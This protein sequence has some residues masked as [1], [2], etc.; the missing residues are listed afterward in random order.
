MK[1][2][3][4]FLGEM[5]NPEVEAFLQA[6]HTVIVPTGA[7]EQHGPH[8]PLAHRRA[9]PEGDRPPR[10]ARRRRRRRAADQLRAVVP[11]RRLHAA[12][13][14]SAS[15]PSWRSSRISATSFAA[16]GFKRIVFLNG[17]Y[18]NTY[19]IAYA[20]ANAAEKLPRGREGIP[21]Q[22]LGRDA[23]RGARAST[24]SLEKGMHAN[25]AETSAVLAINPAPGRHGQGQRRVPAVPGVHGEQRRGAHGVLLQRPRVGVLAPRS[26]ARGATRAWPPAEMGERYLEAGVRVDD[27]RA[28]E[29]R[30]HLRRDAA[31]MSPVMGASRRS[32]AAL[33]PCAAAA[34]RR[35]LAV[36]RA[37]R[38]GACDGASGRRRRDRAR[39]LCR[40]ARI[41]TS[42]GS[43][44][45]ELP[46]EGATA[47]LLE[48]TSQQWLTEQEVE[49]PLWTHWLTVVRPARRSTSDIGL[50]F[51]TGGG[52]DGRPPDAPP[53]W[54]VD[55][56]RDTGTVVA[57]LRHGAEP[58]GRL[59]GRSGARSRAR[60]TTSSPTRGIKFLRTGDE[61]WP[62]RLPMTKSAV[63]AMDAVTAFTAIARRRR[64]RPSTR[65]V[66]SGAS[67]RGWTT[68]TTAA[69]DR[70]VVAIAPPS[71]TCSTSSRRSST[72]GAP[73]APGADAV[74][75]YVE[76]GI[77]DWMGTPRVPRADADR[78]AVRVPRPA[79][80]AEVPGE[81]AGRSVLPA[82]LVAVL[83]RRPARREVRSATCRTSATG[84]TR[85]TRSRRCRRSTRRSSPAG[86]ARDSRGAS[87]RT[88]RCA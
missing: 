53:A 57:E 72:T 44:L 67:K 18:D 27:R 39:S 52:N 50:L 70:R 65:F 45:R 63:R 80:D 19:A 82:G 34:A 3:T 20:C 40:G 9:H 81:R 61:T 85:R 17:H 26:R 84:S 55:V 4:V 37:V 22:L 59:Q 56:A 1:P 71:S 69:V 6:H 66:V 87:S 2:P 14:T 38:P 78:G 83:L 5:T 42:R 46:A 30:A 79:D 88:A 54:L 58:A 7:T 10:R 68:W 15:R 29:H 62:A 75:D 32:L 31:A 51:I 64:Q 77:M 13:C 8:A 43:R 36:C 47:T 48:M 25:A 16:S 41:R 11:A 12:S 21:G 33:L 23:A 35:G 73:T 76:Q 60:R 74:K 28:R 49:R 86:R 24:S